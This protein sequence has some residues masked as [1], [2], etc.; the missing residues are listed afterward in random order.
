MIGCSDKR[1]V[2]VLDIRRGYTTE[3]AQSDMVA[4]LW[5]Y[6]ILRPISFVLTPLFV[7]IGFS[8]NAVTAL[9]LIPLL[10][11][12]AFI[13]LGAISSLNFVVGSVLI[14]IWLLCDCIDGNIA[15]FLGQ[16]SRFGRFFDYIVGMILSVS[17]PL[18]LGLALCLADTEWSV[19]ALR[20]DIPGWFWLLTGAVKLSASLF[21]HIVSLQ[22]R[23]VVGEDQ[24][25]DLRDPDNISIWTI[26]PRAIPSFQLP[27]LLVAALVGMLGFYLF[28]YAVYNLVSLVAM[29]G[30][31]LRKAW[32]TDQRFGK[33][34]VSEAH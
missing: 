15:R 7:N 28:G 11:G 23:R 30:L 27:L 2:S 21:R 31:T 19:V 29:I 32:L 17:L 13:A 25:V 20:L 24:A 14:N 18:C 1:R 8:A 16:S 22:I 6:L 34:Q 4:H 3:K 12:L 26:L 9:G 10:G 5:I 33:E